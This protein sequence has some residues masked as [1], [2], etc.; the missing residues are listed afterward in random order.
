MARASL[1]AAGVRR[2]RGTGAA[3]GTRDVTEAHARPLSSWERVASGAAASRVKALGAKRKNRN[4]CLGRSPLTSLGPSTLSHKGRE[5][6]A[7][8]SR[9]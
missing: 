1:A 4:E 3:A 8:A 2:G 9:P 6:Q 7:R 5:L